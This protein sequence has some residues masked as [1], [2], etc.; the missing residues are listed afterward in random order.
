[1]VTSLSRPYCWTGLNAQNYCKS[2][3][4]AL[5]KYGILSTEADIFRHRL[6]KYFDILLFN[7]SF[8]ILIM[9]NICIAYF[10][11]EVIIDTLLS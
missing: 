3:Y 1:M 7:F 11:Y 5:V 6:Q 2:I 8:I 10:M 4:F 9:Y